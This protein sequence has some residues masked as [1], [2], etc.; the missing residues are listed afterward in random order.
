MSTLY[1][2]TITEKTSGNGVQIPGHV[3]QF[4]KTP[5][6]SA[7]QAVTSNTFVDVTGASLSITP[8]ATNSIILLHWNGHLSGAGS[9]RFMR[10]GTALDLS[11]TAG[12]Y[13]YWDM[14]ASGQSGYDNNST[15]TR[16]AEHIYDE[17]VTISSVTY[18]VQMAAY[19]SINNVGFA[20]NES[21]PRR[22]GSYFSL[23]E[24]AQ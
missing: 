19:A 3:V 2:D 20:I 9:F 22:E 15:R 5:Y 24:I 10:N 6:I 11:N 4:K 8:L 18:K 17:P 1:V 14:D 12:T 23:M 7:T 13:Y 16:F 21:G